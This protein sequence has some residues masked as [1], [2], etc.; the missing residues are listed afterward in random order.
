[1]RHSCVGML[2]DEVQVC[3]TGRRRLWIEVAFGAGEQ[4][5]ALG[6]ILKPFGDAR[7]TQIGSVPGWHASTAPVG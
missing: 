6:V 3:Q 5:A 7:C 2:G 1:L 4:H